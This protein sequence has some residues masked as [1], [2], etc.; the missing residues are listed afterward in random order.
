MIGRR[1]AGKSVTAVGISL[2]GLGV[3]MTVRRHLRVFERIVLIAPF[4]GWPDD[5]AR[6]NSGVEP[7]PKDNLDR[8]LIAVWRWLIDGDDRPPIALPAS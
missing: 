2:G 7:A 4:L 8:E 6:L 3:L 5:V 1:L